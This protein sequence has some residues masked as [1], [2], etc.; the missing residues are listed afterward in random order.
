ML[1]QVKL[2]SQ[3]MYGLPLRY[4]LGYVGCTFEN[5]PLLRMPLELIEVHVSETGHRPAIEI[6]FDEDGR[7]EWV[8]PMLFLS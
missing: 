8:R 2:R 4:Y 1:P 7:P 6:C 3:I 5:L